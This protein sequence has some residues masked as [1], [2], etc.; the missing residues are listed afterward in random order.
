MRPGPL[1]LFLL[2]LCPL[3]TFM[4]HP[5]GAGD[6][7]VAPRFS[8]TANYD[9]NINF[10]YR[11]KKSDVYFNISPSVDFKYDS[12]ISQ[13]TG[14][15]ALK[16][17]AYVQ[18]SGLNGLNQNYRISGQRKMA[19]RLALTFSGAYT[20]D[21]TQTEELTASGVVINRSRR[22]GLQA[23][24]GLVFNLTERASMQ[25]G[26]NYSQATYQDPRYTDYFTHSMNLGLNY[27]LKNAKT[28]LTGTLL[29]RFTDYP[30]IGNS[31]RNFGTYAGLEHKFSE[32]WSLALSGGANFNWFSSQTAVL[33]FGDFGEFPI[34]IQFRQK[35]EETFT[36]SP[37]FNIAANRRWTKTNLTFGY[38]VDQSPS[39]SGTVNQ[40]HSGYVGLSRNFTERLRGT[41]RGSL[42]YSLSSN[43]GSNYEYFTVTL[44]PEL[45]YQLTQRISVNSSYQYGWRED[46]TGGRTADRHLFGLSLS[47]TPIPLHYKK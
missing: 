4:C 6:W 8:L 41:V 16:Y 22:Q 33:D 40:F 46:L 11:E 19:P 1:R 14:S 37:F 36:I 43:P 38:K 3:L 15:L 18:E 24:P 10:S 13:L 25:M 7:Y 2:L 44:T 21:S 26:Y 20:L 35:T 12:E 30:S 17:L 27:L 23:A 32:D 39:A 31:Y 29:G 9:S 47:Y 34:Y 42:Y 45:T 28:T 5:A